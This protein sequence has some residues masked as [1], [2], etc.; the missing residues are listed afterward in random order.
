LERKT[1]RLILRLI[2]RVILRWW[3]TLWFLP[4]A[5]P[6][7]SRSVVLAFSPVAV[8]AVAAEWL[9]AK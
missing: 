3:G 8:L 2:L 1:V 6:A 9:C 4:V 7:L 5:L